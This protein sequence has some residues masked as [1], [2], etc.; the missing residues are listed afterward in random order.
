MR[1]VEMSTDYSEAKDLLERLSLEAQNRLADNGINAVF[2]VKDCPNPEKVGLHL[3]VWQEGVFLAGEFH[4]WAQGMDTRPF[5]YEK[6]FMA[7]CVGIKHAEDRIAFL[8]E[9]EESMY[10]KYGI[11]PENAYLN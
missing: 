4:L 11:P 5:M 2:V 9:L 6:F 3:Q 10:Y 8:R 7:L 1:R